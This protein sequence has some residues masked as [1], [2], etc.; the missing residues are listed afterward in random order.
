MILFFCLHY[1]SFHFSYFIQLIQL[2]SQYDLVPSRILNLPIDVPYEVLSLYGR[3]TPRLQSI[4]SINSSGTYGA[5]DA[6]FIELL[7]TAPVLVA[8]SPTLTMNTGCHN[9]G[10]NNESFDS[11]YKTLC[12]I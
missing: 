1:Q 9:Y 2:K 10:K 12:V 6:L 5:G 4:K 7:Y 3:L 8:A 11:S